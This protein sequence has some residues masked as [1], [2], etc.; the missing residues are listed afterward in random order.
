MNLVGLKTTYRRV[1]TTKQNNKGND[2]Q[3]KEYTTSSFTG[4]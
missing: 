2:D 4:T 3:E 1:N